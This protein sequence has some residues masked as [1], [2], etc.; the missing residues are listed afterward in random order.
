MDIL[1]MEH[2]FDEFKDT[3][4]LLGRQ[5]IYHNKPVDVMWMDIFRELETDFLQV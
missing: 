5:L 3:K 2:L 1:D 4:D